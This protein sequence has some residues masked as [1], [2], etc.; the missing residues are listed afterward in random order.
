MKRRHYGRRAYQGRISPIM[1]SDV[2]YSQNGKQRFEP[3][4]TL[5]LKTISFGT[6][7]G[8]QDYLRR[9]RGAGR[10]VSI[11]MSAVVI[12]VASAMQ[13]RSRVSPNNHTVTVHFA[14]ANV[15]RV[16]GRQQSASATRRANQKTCPAPLRKNILIC[17][18]NIPV[19]RIAKPPTYLSR[20]VPQRGGSRSSRT[21][22]R[23]RW[24]QAAP[25]TRA[26]NLRTVKSCGPDAPTLA[27]SSRKNFC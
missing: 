27:S 25:K 7:G 3:Q 17:E 19:Y 22:G 20:P 15:G 23:M 4:R 1:E 9:P 16:N 14:N 11:L 8:G 5:L 12:R 18:T 2:K 6:S 13:Q 10:W 26:L 21:R 24:T